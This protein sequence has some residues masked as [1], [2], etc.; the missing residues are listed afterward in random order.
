MP[1][2]VR[3][4]FAFWHAWMPASLL[5]CVLHIFDGNVCVSGSLTYELSE[6]MAFNETGLSFGTSLHAFARQRT[7]FIYRAM[8]H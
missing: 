7:L 1:E 6:Y 5:A 2:H 3:L 4:V 8:R